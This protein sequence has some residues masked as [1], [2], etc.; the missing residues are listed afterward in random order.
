VRMG[1]LSWAVLRLAGEE[2]PV[3]RTG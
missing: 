2:S 3:M 1:I